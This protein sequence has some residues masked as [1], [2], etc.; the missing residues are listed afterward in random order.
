MGS[1]LSPVIA[2]I[3]MEHIEQQ[4]IATFPHDVP[5]WRRYVDDTFV[6]MNKNH[7]ELFHSH[8]NSID[9]NI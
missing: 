5:L 8:L 9:Q 7:I 4:A 3:V 1:S 6:I 2:N